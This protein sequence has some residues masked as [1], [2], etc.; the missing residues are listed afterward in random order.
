MLNRILIDPQVFAVQKGT[1]NGQVSLDELDAR[2]KLDNIV[3]E[4][5]PLT[6]CFNGGVDAFQRSFLNLTLS[7]SLLL[8][9][10]RCLQSVTFDLNENVRIVLFN[11]EQDLD[12]A[13][14]EDEELEGILLKSELDLFD[15][16]EDQILMA[17]PFAPT[18]ETC[19]NAQLVHINQDE[20]NPFAVLAG[21]KKS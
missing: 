18:H 16:I 12:K 20:P 4:V 6:Y 11:N 8:R 19:N 7:G 21:L 14:L 2:I 9:C 10:Q 13:M 3:G 5:S 1:L 17:I 15:L